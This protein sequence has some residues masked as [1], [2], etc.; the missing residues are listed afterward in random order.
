MVCSKSAILMSNGRGCHGHVSESAN[1]H[2]RPLLLRTK[3]LNGLF[4]IGFFNFHALDGLFRR[5]LP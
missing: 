2:T 5:N 3:G 1:I 4:E